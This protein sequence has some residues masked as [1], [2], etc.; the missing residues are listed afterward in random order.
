M[1]NSITPS[2]VGAIF[3]QFM[4]DDNAHDGSTASSPTK[5]ITMFM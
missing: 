2:V 5:N 3:Y 4:D 1:K